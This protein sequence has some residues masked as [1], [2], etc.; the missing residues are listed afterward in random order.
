MPDLPKISA[1]EYMDLIRQGVG[2]A[3]VASLTAGEP[4]PSLGQLTTA[5]IAGMLLA[6]GAA[7]KPLAAVMTAREV[8]DCVFKTEGE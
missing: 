2:D 3:F 4:Q 8:M 7:K 1:F 6:T 5:L